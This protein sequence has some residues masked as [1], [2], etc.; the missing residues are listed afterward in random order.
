M[1]KNKQKIEDIEMTKARAMVAHD[2]MSR[3]WKLEIDSEGY[4]VAEKDEAKWLIKVIPSELPSQGKEA[5]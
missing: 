3:G 4:L 1:T 5:K 2:L